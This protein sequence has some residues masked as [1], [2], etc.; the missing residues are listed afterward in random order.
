MSNK[1][2]ISRKIIGIKIDV[3]TK[4]DKLW[5]N[6]KAAKELQIKRNYKAKLVTLNVEYSSL[7]LRTLSLSQL[8]MLL[9]PNIF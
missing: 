7:L 3:A 9:N 6:Y 1:N 2:R 5:A 8:D 4:T